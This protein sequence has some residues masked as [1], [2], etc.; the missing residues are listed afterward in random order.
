MKTHKITLT[1]QQLTIEHDNRTSLLQT[2]EN[3]GIF[4]EYQCRLGYCGACRVKLRKGKVSYTE[5]PLA[6]LQS[7]DMLL[8]CC[9]VESDLEIEF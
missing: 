4:H 3:N 6:F 8:C 5:L 9:K 2:L 7:D 1:N